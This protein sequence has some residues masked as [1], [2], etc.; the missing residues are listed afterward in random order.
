[1][2]LY[3]ISIEYLDKILFSFVT[4]SGDEFSK[5]LSNLMI[6]CLIKVSE[7]KTIVI[8][9]TKKKTMYK[10]TNILKNKYRFVFK[11]SI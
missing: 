8:F 11:I 1:M 5:M 4:V 6:E 9:V 2:L 3:L 10:E 7:K